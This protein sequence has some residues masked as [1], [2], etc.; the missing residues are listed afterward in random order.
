MNVEIIVEGGIE[1]TIWRRERNAS[2]CY[3]SLWLTTGVV[4]TYLCYRIA[5]RISVA[6]IASAKG[7]KC[8]TVREARTSTVV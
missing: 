7:I 3:N 4:A 6:D 2:Q 1:G 8:P 5:T